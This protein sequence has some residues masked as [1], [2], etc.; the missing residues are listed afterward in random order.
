MNIVNYLFNPKKIHSEL[1]M[2]DLKL[3]TGKKICIETCAD[4]IHKFMANAPTTRT[5]ITCFRCGEQGHYKSECFNW[6]TRMCWHYL[7]SSCKDLDCS[8]AHGPEELR[9]P[10]LSRCVRIIKKDGQLISLGCKEY[11]HTFKYCPYLN[12][13]GGSV[14]VDTK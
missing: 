10:W 2:H 12:S 8:F 13:T 14:S 4:S 6:K 9:T 7:N 1:Q 11:G 3:P 5:Q